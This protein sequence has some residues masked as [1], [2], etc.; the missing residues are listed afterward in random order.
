MTHKYFG[1]DGI[2]G[3]ANQGHLSPISVVSI[4]QAYAVF[5][6][7]QYTNI[8]E[9]STATPRVRVIIGKDTRRSCYTIENLITGALTSMGIDVF[10]LGPIPTPGVSYLVAGL[11]AQGG[12]MISASHNLFADNGLKFFAASG[13]K[14]TA[15]DEMEIEHLIPQD[16][17]PFLACAGSIGK[18]TR[19]DDALAQYAVF[20]KEKFPKKYNLSGMKIV[21]DCANGAA[22]KVAP[23]VFIE[24]GAEVI[25][26][27]NAPNGVNINQE[28]GATSPQSLQSAVILSK[29]HIGIA[30]DGDA[31]RLIVVDEK[32]QI[33]DGDKI[34]AICAKYAA[35]QNGLNRIC[36]THMS[37]R[38]L[39]MCLAPYGVSVERVDIGDRNVVKAM[40]ENTVNLGGESSGHLI[41]LDSVST[42]DGILA[43]LK[44]LEIMIFSKQPISQ[45]GN[46][47]IKVPQIQLQYKVAN[48]PPLATLP[49]LQNKIQNI[50]N[51]LAETGMVL[52]RYSGTE[53]LVRI[54]VEGPNY[55]TIETWAHEILDILKSE[56]LLQSS[57]H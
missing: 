35:E 13:F 8:Q 50:Q 28:C 27:N 2:R 15:Q 37:N 11:R 17:T 26:I 47:F 7:S 23:K 36:V 21:V 41:F 9:T 24:L 40:V 19:L 49:T 12:I 18:A 31:D 1:T 14:I 39:D 44:L 52:V 51:T 38:G 57:N 45:M 20:L 30:L 6:L 22:Y 16:K 34:L 42:G 56:P 29:A 43:A 54:T 3:P 55:Q 5:L 33:V 32:G 25:A 48:K 46:F 10:L 53:P 4:A